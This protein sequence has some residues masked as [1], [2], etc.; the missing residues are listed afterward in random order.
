MP[1]AYA[2]WAAAER[3]RGLTAYLQ[4]RD[5]LPNLS[6]LP[7]DQAWAEFHRAHDHRCAICRGAGGR[8]VIDHD[9][10]TGLVRGLL[11]RSCN[12]DAV[13]GIAHQSLTEL[14]DMSPATVLYCQ[15][16]P[17]AV[18]GLREVYVS[19]FGHP[20]ASRVH[21]VLWHAGPEGI[22]PDWLVRLGPEPPGLSAH[23][24]YRMAAILAGG[25]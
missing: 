15:W 5:A 16:P 25:S 14:S 18:A 6:G 10:T 3:R 24:A 2:L 11:C 4:W 23:A 20:A 8:L 12:A 21:D 19:P 17:S 1:T 22:Q 9:H 7:R 13:S